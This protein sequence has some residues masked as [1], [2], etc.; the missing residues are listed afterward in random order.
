[1]CILAPGLSLGPRLGLS[2]EPPLDPESLPPRGL[3]SL[4]PLDILLLA[5]VG[6]SFLNLGAPGSVLK[7][8][9]DSEFLRLNFTIFIEFAPLLL[10][11]WDEM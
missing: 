6:F 2:L 1:M 10:N 11:L 5:L 4:P 3:E 7:L 8:S 9:E